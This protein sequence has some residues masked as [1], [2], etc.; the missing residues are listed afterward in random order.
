MT[1][2]TAS[3]KALK[4]KVIGPAQLVDGFAAS[5]LE[6]SGDFSATAEDGFSA[7]A[8]LDEL[9]IDV[10]EARSA[11]GDRALVVGVTALSRVDFFNGDGLF[12]FA[13][14][15]GSWYRSPRKM[16]EPPELD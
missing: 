2:R 5:G 7:A 8:A 14:N 13:A 3:S 12:D 10:S 6:T 1:T 15:G 4:P 9:E 16:D 11:F